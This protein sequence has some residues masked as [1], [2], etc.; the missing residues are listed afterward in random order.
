MFLFL[1]PEMNFYI[2]FVKYERRERMLQEKILRRTIFDA[3]QNTK[4]SMFLK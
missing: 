3:L 1:N 2:Y 4:I